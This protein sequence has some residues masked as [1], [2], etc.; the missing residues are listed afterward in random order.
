MKKFDFS[1]II[2][3]YNEKKT[4]V[5]TLNL[6]INQSITPSEV[7]FI[8]S[9][10]SDNTCDIIQNFIFNNKLDNWKVINTDFQ[11]PSE[12]KN[13]GIKI[14]KYK[15]C[16]F[17][18]FDLKFSN[19]W[20]EDQIN[21]I[22]ENKNLMISYGVVNLNPSNY[23]DKLVIAQ[24]YGLK[25]NNPVIPSSF[26]KKKYF[27]K[28]GYFLPLRSLYDKIFIKQ[29]LTKNHKYLAINNNVNVEYVD[30]NY[31]TNFK[32]LFIKIINYSLQT[33]F[34]NQNKIPYIY[35]LIFLSAVIFILFNFY[36]IFIIILF[37]ILLR[38]FIIPIKKNKNFFQKFS[39]FEIP[40]L[41]IVGISIDFFKTIGFL[42]SFV[43]KI[44]NKKVRLDKYYK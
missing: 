30:I 19:T 24:T 29:S 18:D 10:S 16:A 6:I 36:F 12:S 15:W 8:N 7:L 40:Y 33:T 35:L 1:L 32:D 43:L 42:M 4:A 27:E 2:P 28:Y 5:F 38:G 3:F 39:I 31:A 34:Y 17:M 9:K 44:F 11:T 22:N 25:S 41:F 37:S 14:S 26:I 21:F 23:F 13:L 20:L